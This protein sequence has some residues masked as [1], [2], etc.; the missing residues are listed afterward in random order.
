MH[1]VLMISFTSS[2]NLPY[3]ILFLYFGINTM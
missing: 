3:R 2:L 1:N